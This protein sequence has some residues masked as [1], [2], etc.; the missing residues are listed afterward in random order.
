MH[1]KCHPSHQL[2][3]LSCYQLGVKIGVVHFKWDMK[4]NVFFRLFP[5]RM[6]EINPKDSGNWGVP[7]Y[8]LHC[9]GQNMY[10]HCHDSA[11]VCKKNKNSNW[12]VSS[13]RWKRQRVRPTRREGEPE[14]FQPVFPGCASGRLCFLHRDHRVALSWGNPRQNPERLLQ[15]GRGGDRKTSPGKEGREGQVQR[16]PHSSRAAQRRRNKTWGAHARSHLLSHPNLP[17]KAVRVASRV[18]WLQ[19]QLECR[20]NAGFLHRPTGPQLLIRCYGCSATLVREIIFDVM[21]AGLCLF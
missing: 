12:S 17:Q 8:N 5:R 11:A 1:I 18:F 2:E 16:S 6:R 15:G 4:W 13:Y 14:S 9:L 10:K 21:A 7:G 19:I 3:A 20:A